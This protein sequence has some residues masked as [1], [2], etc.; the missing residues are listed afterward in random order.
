VEF[1]GS[2][3]TRNALLPNI[4]LYELLGQI[5]RN[6]SGVKLLNVFKGLPISYDVRI[7][8]VSNS[9]IQVHSN[10]FQLACLY[11]Q[12]ETYLQGDEL[13]FIVYSQVLS[14]HLGK[15]D[16]TLTNL[17][18]MPNSIGNR[19][20]IRVEPNEPLVASLRFNP[21]SPEFFVPLTDISGEGAGAYFEDYMFPAKLCRPGNEI[22]MTINLPDTSSQKMKKL[23]TKPLMTSQSVKSY[24]T[25]DSLRN[26]DSKVAVTTRGKI[27]SVR[28]ELGLKRYRVGMRL[29][30]KD[31]SRSVVLQ[32]ISQRQSEIIRDLSVLSN[33]LYSLKK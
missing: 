16:A 18:T 8:T 5:A 7:N 29:Y 9:E 1:L 10:R 12:R 19:M 14:L 11:Y 30:F 27:V 4:N 23:P 26:Q 6:R 17:E 2:L 31:L 25:T 15:E 28:P 20:Q 13:P 33:E 3:K 24:L 22:S 32:Y 21:S